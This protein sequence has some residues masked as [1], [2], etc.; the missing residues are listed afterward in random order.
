MAIGYEARSYA[1]LK[2]QTASANGPWFMIGNFGFTSITIEGLE[3]GGSVD[4]R[5]SNRPVNDPPPEEYMGSARNGVAAYTSNVGFL[6]SGYGSYIWIRAI[7][8]AG[9]TPTPTSVYLAGQDPR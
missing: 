8:T 4:F 5:I 9:A 3:A 6:L 1:L 7:K 2:D